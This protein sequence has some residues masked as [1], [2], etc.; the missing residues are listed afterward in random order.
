MRQR[1]SRSS[2][3]FST[4]ST[5]LHLANIGRSARLKVSAEWSVFFLRVLPPLL[6]PAHPST[7]RRSMQADPK[8]RQV[9]P[10]YS[11][12]QQIKFTQKRNR[13]RLHYVGEESSDSGRHSS[14]LPAETLNSVQS[15]AASTL[16]WLR[17]P[18]FT[19]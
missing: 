2:S 10:G 11:R 19:S 13:R 12:A 9:Q 17:P 6:H 16:L 7:H 14:S 3:N 18:L 15:R 1:R 8:P 4:F 5:L